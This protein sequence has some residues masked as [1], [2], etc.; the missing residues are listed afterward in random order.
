MVEVWFCEL[1]YLH[2]DVISCMVLVD[3]YL[4]KYIVG[5]LILIY[6]HILV[7]IVRSICQCFWYMIEWYMF[8]SLWLRHSIGWICIIVRI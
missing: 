4:V 5:A 1:G 6:L 3:A 2:K 7:C 8:E